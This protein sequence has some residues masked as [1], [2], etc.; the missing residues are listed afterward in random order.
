MSIETPRTPGP[1]NNESQFSPE[2]H[3]RYLKGEIETLALSVLQKLRDK[4]KLKD[5]LFSDQDTAEDQ[6]TLEKIN[7]LAPETVEVQNNLDAF[8]ALSP[9]EREAEVFKIFN[10]GQ[11]RPKDPIVHTIDHS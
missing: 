11:E 5:G 4:Q 10:N 6:K 8:Y 3:G 9:E 1:S 2:L 7:L